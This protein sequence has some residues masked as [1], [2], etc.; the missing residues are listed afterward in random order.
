VSWRAEGAAWHVPKDSI[1]Q[2]N[3]CGSLMPCADVQMHVLGVERLQNQLCRLQPSINRSCFCLSCSL[4]CCPYS[5]PAGPALS[6][7][8]EPAERLVSSSNPICCNYVFLL[9]VIAHACSSSSS[10]AALMSCTAA[11]TT[12]LDGSMCESHSSTVHCSP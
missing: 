8:K 9:N 11:A 4:M 5:L 1:R 2:R 7:V 6:Y 12:R 3:K 10:S